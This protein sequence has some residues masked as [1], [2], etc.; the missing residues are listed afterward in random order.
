MPPFSVGFAQVEHRLGIVRRR[1]NLLA[2][3]D[4]VYKSGSL[5]A[6]AAALLVGLALRGRAGFFAVAAWTAVAAIGA[7]VTAAL[8][9]LRRGWRSR[10]QIVR[11]AD[12]QA[13]L[14]DRLATLLLAPRAAHTSPFKQL[15]LEQVLAATPRWD[16]DTLA[17]RRVPRSAYALLAA[18]VALMATSFFVRPPATPQP[19]AAARQ[20]H[21]Q[22]ADATDPAQ[23]QHQQQAE[24][25]AGAPAAPGAAGM[26]SLKG[27]GEGSQQMQLGDAASAGQGADPKHP[28]I[29]FGAQGIPSA[30]GQA[31]KNGDARHQEHG[32]EG[33]AQTAQEGTDKLTDKLQD[34]IRQ[35]MGA[36]P[37]GTGKNGDAAA[38]H[39]GER[40][41]D[42]RSTANQAGARG[43][44][45]AG[46]KE[47]ANTS[48]PSGRSGS[49]PGA[50]AGAGKESAQAGSELFG[51]QMVARAAGNE[52]QRMA[53]KLGA[54][55]ATAPNNSEPQ[56]PPPP[57]QLPVAA[58]GHNPPPALSEEQIPDAPQQKVDVAPE[59]ETVVR[60][61]FTRE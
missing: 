34:A 32:A 51:E 6:L 43:N 28:P 46:Q 52:S 21:P 41:A 30:P 33:A 35:A 13:A 44:G 4:A 10:D 53:I 23:Q 5:V 45:D 50:G 55:A 20:P 9:H 29:Q 47:T 8:L 40:G 26:A 12:R 11:W 37:S 56:P 7:A 17:P 22:V 49:M 1:L 18:L 58:A 3:Q 16:I 54:F 42:E 57:G 15:L 19:T 14:E 25:S 27:M 24:R 48:P 60:R 2:L 39:D 59:H 38:Q 36:A 31:G 61:I